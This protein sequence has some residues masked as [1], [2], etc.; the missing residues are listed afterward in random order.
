MSE[1]TNV[2]ARNMRDLTTPTSTGVNPNTFDNA[3]IP[4]GNA[5]KG[6]ESAEALTVKQIKD[7]AANGRKEELDVVTLRISTEELRAKEVEAALIKDKANKATTILGY[8]ITDAYTQVQIDSKVNNLESKKANKVEVETAFSNLSTTANKYYST[9]A[10]ATADIANIALNQSVTIGEAANGG[11]W[12]KATA[13]ATSLTKSPYDPLTQANQYTNSSVNPIKKLIGVDESELLETAVDQDGFA[14]RMT[15]AEGNVRFSGKKLGFNDSGIEETINEDPLIILDAEN[16]VVLHMDEES[17]LHVPS[18]IFFRGKSLEE[19]LKDA[20]KNISSEKTYRKIAGQTYQNAMISR[21]QPMSQFTSIMALSESNGLINR[22]IAGVRISTGLFV[23]WHQQTTPQYDGDGSGS[24]FWSAFV[25]IN[26]NLQ[27]T[28]RDK[29]L[30]IYPDT[31]AGIVK[32]PHLGWTNNNRLIMVYEK[33][34]GYAEAT[35]G[36]PV[37][38]IKYAVY[39]SDEGVTWTSP[40]LLK[41]VNSP[42]TTQLKALGTTCEVL[43]LKSG[44]LIVALYSTLGHSGCIYSDDDGLNWVYSDKFIS[45]GNWGFEPSICPDSDGYL[46]M[47]M[48]PKSNTNLHTGF[49][50]SKDNGLSWNMMHSNRVMSVTNQSFL[51]YDEAFG[52]H[53]YSHDVNELNRRTDYRISI[54]YDDCNTFPLTYAPFLDSKY[55]GYTQLMKWSDGVYLLLMEYNDV[56]QG[57]NIN[58]QVGIQIINA[59]EVFNNVTRSKI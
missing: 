19:S 16:N 54:S 4:I 58:E 11:L 14:Y 18:D 50:R 2:F 34:V 43:K 17:N 38:Y 12:Y 10:A 45:E 53:L 28:V 32:H 9:L 33:S 46:V 29:K 6:F 22:M 39:S 25:D 23:V 49:A 15:D 24:A 31:D 26:E 41:Y 8:G 44:R 30:F 13:G 55:V 5:P 3:K 48:R 56:W 7:L 1:L 59:K 27:V 20:A 35:S 42:P 37:N 52:V 51:L 36:N 21:Q 47:A 40:I 57:G